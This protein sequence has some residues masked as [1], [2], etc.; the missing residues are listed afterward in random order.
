MFEGID[1]SLAGVVGA[2]SE[3][4]AALVGI[5][6]KIAEAQGVFSAARLEGTG[7]ALAEALRG[8]DGLIAAVEKTRRGGEVRF[9]A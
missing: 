5:E 7:P 4:R 9:V 1:T 2:G 8:V 3:F 6:K